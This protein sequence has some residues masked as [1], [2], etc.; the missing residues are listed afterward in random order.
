LTKSVVAFA[1]FLGIPIAMLLRDPVRRAPGV[2]PGTVAVSQWLVPPAATPVPDKGRR[3]FLRDCAHCHGERGDGFSRNRETLHPEPFDLTSFELTESFIQR[4]VREGLPATDMPGWSLGTDEEVRAVSAYTARL[5]RRDRLSADESY[6]PP[7]RLFEAGRRIYT[8]HCVSCHGE[9]G[10]GDG[11]DAGQ[12]LPRPSSF[13]DMRPSYAAA[14]RVI[15]NGVHGTAMA[16][17]PL[18]TSPE[19]QAVTFYI[20]TLYTNVRTFE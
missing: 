9:Q 10:R 11:L 15:E 3:I 12:H 1:L 14:R 7:D 17:W 20:R 18:L 2:S 8:M 19:I 13:A 16:S 4:I 6:A 5:G